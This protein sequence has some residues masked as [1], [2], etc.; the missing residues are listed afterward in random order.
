M[1]N[2]FL[3]ILGLFISVVLTLILQEPIEGLV[4]RFFAG[5]LPR[6]KRSIDGIWQ[7]IIKAQIG[8]DRIEHSHLIELKQFGSHI[9]GKTLLEK[10]EVNNN[11]QQFRMTG[12]IYSERFFTGIWES[13]KDRSMYHGTFLFSIHPNGKTITGKFLGI[14]YADQ[15]RNGEWDGKLLSEKTDKATKKQ[16]IAEFSKTWRSEY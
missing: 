3:W 14:G 16:L 10:K 6:P 7:T 4:I 11:E 9:V 13:T 5:I 2:T 15:V 8:D 12:K 1:V